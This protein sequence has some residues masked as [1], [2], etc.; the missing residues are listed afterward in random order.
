MPCKFETEHV[1]NFFLCRKLVVYSVSPSPD[2]AHHGFQKCPGFHAKERPPAY[3]QPRSQI[4]AGSPQ[5]AL[6]GQR[7]MLHV[8][9]MTELW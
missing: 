1:Y 7:L 2:E 4:P 9:L 6:Q 3:S 5:A 8:R